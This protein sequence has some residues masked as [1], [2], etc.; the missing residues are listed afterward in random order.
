M[1][2]LINSTEDLRSK[3]FRISCPSL[4][5]FYELYAFELIDDVICLSVFR[6]QYDRALTW[7]LL[8][9]TTWRAVCHVANQQET[10]DC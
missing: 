3:V 2:V 10:A 8:V 7:H 9:R 4:I 6:K 1:H 5:V